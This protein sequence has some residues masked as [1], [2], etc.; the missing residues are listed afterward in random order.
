[1]PRCPD[2]T[3]RPRGGRI[4]AWAR[5]L[6]ALTS[7]SVISAG[8]PPTRLRDDGRRQEHVGGRAACAGE[9]TVAI[10]ADPAVRARL[11]GVGLVASPPGAKAARE[12]IVREAA[13]N[14]ELMR[15]AGIE[16]E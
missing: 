14:R 11:D 12:R 13:T 1:M 5:E 9:A 3:G 2:A 6:P 7:S 16:P 10:L 15:R 8:T 4:A